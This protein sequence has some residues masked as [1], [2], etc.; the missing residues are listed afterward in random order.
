M[1]SDC[2]LAG[3]SPNPDQQTPRA[4]ELPCCA[5]GNRPIQIQDRC[6]GQ[7]GVGKPDRLTVAAAPIKSTPRSTNAQPPQKAPDP[8]PVV[9]VLV[10]AP[11]AAP[12]PLE[13]G[14]GLGDEVLAPKLLP[15]G[16][17]VGVV[18]DAGV[19][20]GVGL[21]VCLGVGVGVDVLGVGVGVLGV[22]VLVGVG[23]GVGAWQ[24][25]QNVL[26]FR[27][28]WENSSLKW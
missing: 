28:S 27:G 26:C 3:R 14:D 18:V 2:A 20:V 9:G 19:S 22:G 17:G 12:V 25:T 21:G 1:Q 6:S 7:P 4:T 5:N 11:K 24:L 23:V 16:V 13:D 8:A 10:P 15:V